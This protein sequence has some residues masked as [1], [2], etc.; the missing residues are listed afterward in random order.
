MAAIVVALFAVACSSKEP[1]L[2]LRIAGIPDQNSSQ[3]ARRYDVL[4][5]YLSDELGVEVEYVPTVDYSATVIGFKQDE[6]QM[7]WFG[8]LT[9]VQARLAVDGSKAIAQRPRDTEFRPSWRGDTM[10]LLLI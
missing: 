8:G 4:T 1:T 10:F 3:L 5:S 6:I 7:A 9:G 2:T